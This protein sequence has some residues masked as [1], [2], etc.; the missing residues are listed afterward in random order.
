[1]KVDIWRRQEMLLRWISEQKTSKRTTEKKGV[2]VVMTILS[3][4]L[5]STLMEK[6]DR[7][8]PAAHLA[9]VASSF[10][11]YIV[12]IIQEYQIAKNV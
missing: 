2:N 4:R 5:V 12:A 7:S 11:G 9:C 3:V 6:H 8:Y 10:L 1:M